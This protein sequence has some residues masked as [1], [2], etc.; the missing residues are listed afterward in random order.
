VLNDRPRALIERRREPRAP[1]NRR[2]LIR[3]GAQGQELCCT[4]HDLTARGAGLSVGSVFGV[5]GTF[6]LLIDGDSGSRFCRVVWCEGK[7]LG[8]AFE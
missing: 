5:P 6:S 8:V 7:R 4:V 1:T 3:F 2:G